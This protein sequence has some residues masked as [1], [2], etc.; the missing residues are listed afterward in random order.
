MAFLPV[1]PESFSVLS[2]AVSGLTFALLAVDQD[3]A[4]TYRISETGA[5]GGF[6]LAGWDEVGDDSVRISVGCEDRPSYQIGAI[7]VP[8]PAFARLLREA[9]EVCSVHYTRAGGAAS[10][11]KVM[12]EI[13]FHD[14]AS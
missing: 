9:L 8:R 14:P 3:A 13:T 12:I 6:E 4:R 10:D 2:D 7:S 1:H 11:R 5:A